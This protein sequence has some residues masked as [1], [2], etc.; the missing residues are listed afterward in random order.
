MKFSPTKLPGVCI[1][2]LERHED[3]RGFFAR[4]WCRQEFEERGLDPRLVQCNVSFNRKRGTL[5]GMHYQIARGSETG[6][7]HT[8]RHLRR[9]R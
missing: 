5:R 6:A 4:S 2:D 1:V 7:L 8:R 3:E 9:G